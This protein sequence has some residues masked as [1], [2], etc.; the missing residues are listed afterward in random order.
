MEGRSDSYKGSK[1]P[2]RSNVVRPCKWPNPPR[3]C[4]YVEIGTPFNSSASEEVL[5]TGGVTREE[6]PRTQAESQRQPS[7]PHQGRARG[8]NRRVANWKSQK[9]TTVV[10]FEDLWPLLETNRVAIAD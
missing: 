5:F 4:Q 9:V 10:H 7:H 2:R 8:A 6:G 1:A 3:E